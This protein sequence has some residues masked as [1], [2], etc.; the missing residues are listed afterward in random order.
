MFDKCTFGVDKVEF[1]G[2]KISPGGVHPVSSKVEAVVGSL[3]PTSIRAVQEF[4]GMVNYYRRFIP[5][6]THTTA[7]LTEVLKGRPKT[8]EWGHDQQKA[9]SLMKTT[10]AKAT[11]LAHQT[12]ALPSS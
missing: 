12:L 3:T 8:L 11:A 6:I 9:F 1:L 10:L 2:H 7:P 5:G 4:L